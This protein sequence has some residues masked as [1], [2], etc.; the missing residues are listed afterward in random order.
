[1]YRITCDGLLLLDTRLED[2][3]V[4]EPKV[5]VETNTVG[6][7]SFTIYSN[8]PYYNDLHPLKSAFEVSDENGVI[9]RGRMTNDT[10]DFYNGKAVDL[11]GAMAFFND[12]MVRPFVF[13]DDFGT[14][15]SNVNVVWYFLNWLIN[16]HNEQ[17]ELFQQFK[18]GRV[19]VTDPNNYIARSSEN[20]ASTWDTLKEKL[21]DSSLGGYLCIRY[22]EDGNYIDYLADFEDVNTQ[23]IRLGQNLLDMKCEVDASATYSAIIPIGADI[24]VEEDGE[25]ITK[26]LTLESIADGKLNNADDTYKVTLDNGLHAIYSKSA[27]EEYGWICCPVEEATWDD[28]TDA[29]NLKNKA[30]EYL[31]GTASLLGDNIEVTAADLHFADAE[32]RSFRIYKKVNVISKPHDINTYY[33]LSKL[34]IDLLNPQNTKIVVGTPKKTLTAAVSD[35]AKE[36]KYSA[37]ANSSSGGGGGIA[38]ETDPTVSSWAKQPNK[39]TYTADEV[40]ALPSTTKIPSK[41]S[42]LTNDSGFITGIPSEYVTDSELTAKGYLTSIPSI[43][44]TEEELEAKH[45]LTSVPDTY[46]TKTDLDTRGYLTETD[47]EMELEQLVTEAEV[48]A[49]IDSKGFLTDSALDTKLGT[50]VTE[51]ELGAKGY[52]TEADLDLDNYS[53]VA[54]GI[55]NKEFEVVENANKNAN[56]FLEHYKERIDRKYY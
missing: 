44:V 6:E 55:M 11:E 32:V 1:M 52:V 25:T 48:E 29:N 36:S 9:F 28:V 20:I 39:P 33:N 3:I 30:R 41:T 42:D 16:Q 47:L 45:Y 24:E 2:Y 34:E 21:F 26:K 56:E 50:Y 51:A 18:L 53:T 35:G 15:S 31:L 37:S 4:L 54:G 7:C 19:T 46:V 13:P 10:R 5:N 49:L 8:H 17:V 22:E 23:E 38:E 40:G 14:I 27:V 43:Y 12:S